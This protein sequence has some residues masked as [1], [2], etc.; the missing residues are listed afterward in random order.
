VR[1]LLL[2]KSNVSVSSTKVD[3]KDG[4]VT[5]TGSADS[6]AQKELTETYVREVEGVKR[7]NNSLVVAKPVEPPRT[8][9][10]VL[11]DASI[12]AQVKYA[13]LTHHST[14]AIDT[15]VSTKD[16]MVI[17]TGEADNDAER[18]LVTKLVQAVR[19]VRSVRNDMTLKRGE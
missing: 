18:D 11:D 12:T 1:A 8:M 7:V 9:G 5:L 2:M 14:S 16:G 10:D 15:K 6:V 19:G 4:V 13:L 3:V 17:I